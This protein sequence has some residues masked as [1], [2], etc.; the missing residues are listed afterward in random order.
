[1]ITTVGNHEAEI[2]NRINKGRI[3]ISELNCVLWNQNMT[4]KIKPRIYHA[5]LKVQ[6]HVQRYVAIKKKCKK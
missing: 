6:L 1:M 2:K 5:L 3:A 4:P